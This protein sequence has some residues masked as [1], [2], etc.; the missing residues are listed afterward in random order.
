MHAKTTIPLPYSVPCVSSSAKDDRK[1]RAR[2]HLKHKTLP[3]CINIIYEKRNAYTT[4]CSKNNSTLRM[5]VQI[6]VL[7]VITNKQL[8]K[9][10]LDCGYSRL[11]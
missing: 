7:G 6:C 8:S 5:T 2:F 1:N 3:K 11:N 9:H 10:C 4:M